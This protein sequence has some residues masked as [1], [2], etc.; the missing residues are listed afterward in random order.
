V[1]LPW[2]V[3]DLEEMVRLD[4]ELGRVDLPWVVWG[5][6]EMGRLELE[7]GHQVMV[8]GRPDLE[9]GQEGLL[10][11]SVQQNQVVVAS[12]VHHVPVVAMGHVPLPAMVLGREEWGRLDLEMGHRVMVLGLEGMVHPA[13][14]VVG[15]VGLPWVVLG[16]EQMGRLDLEV[17]HAEHQVMVLGRPDLEMGHERHFVVRSRVVVLHR[18][19]EVFYAVDLLTIVAS[20]VHHVLVCRLVWAQGLPLMVLGREEMG[21]LDLELG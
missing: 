16:L 10:H 2:G 3:L 11:V 6:E 15:H 14:V 12:H 17:G 20:H 5:L 8:L 18:V 9:M 7:L 4:L 19:V 1:D 13:A 21:H